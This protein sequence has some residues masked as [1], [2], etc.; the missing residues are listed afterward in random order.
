MKSGKN[1]KNVVYWYRHTRRKENIEV[2]YMKGY[3][4]VQTTLDLL[5]FLCGVILI[6]M[7]CKLGWKYMIQKRR[8]KARTEGIVVGYAKKIS[9]GQGSQLRL[10]IVEYM[11][12][13]KLYRVTGP[14]YRAYITKTT[15]VTDKN[16]E[17]HQ[18]TTDVHKQTFR[19]NIIRGDFLT[20]VANPMET[21]F[22]QGSH[23][24]VYYDPEQPK[25]AYVLRYCKCRYVFWLPV[26]AGFLLLV[27]EFILM[28]I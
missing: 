9:G 13:G 2:L 24:P 6:V 15:S 1:R 8:C 27:T 10:P 16:S 18:F 19:E 12:E 25:L 21:L 11:V 22:P 17:R 23:V 7:G 4:S 14:E 26:L 5:L 28:I 20:V 3:S